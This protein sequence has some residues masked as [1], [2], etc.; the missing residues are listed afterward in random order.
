[1]EILSKSG[2]IQEY[3]NKGAEFLC[4][5]AIIKNKKYKVVVMK[6]E[7]GSYRFLSVIPNIRIGIRDNY[8]D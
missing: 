3:E 5:V 1:M 4:F 6:S 2:T 7:S 8:L